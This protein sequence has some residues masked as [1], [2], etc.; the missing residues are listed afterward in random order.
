MKNITK[1]FMGVHALK[2]VNFTACKGKVS[3][4]IGEHGA[5]EYRR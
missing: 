1:S 4:L 2:N 5:G 3:I